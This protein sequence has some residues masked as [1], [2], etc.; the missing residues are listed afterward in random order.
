VAAARATGDVVQLQQS[1]YD[2]GAQ[3][4]DVRARIAVLT[5]SLKRLEGLLDE[6]NSVSDVI[7]LEDAI[8]QRQAELDS[9][10]AQ[11]RELADQTQMAQ[12]SLTLMSPDDAEQLVDPEPQ[13]TWWESFVR[14]L[15]QFWSWLGQALLVLSPLLIVAAI[16]LWVRRRR[17]RPGRTGT[18]EE[19]VEAP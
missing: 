7:R 16:L 13:L 5:A 1:S 18:V 15:S 14:G 9:L 6:A 19:S 11:Q 4:T 3:V 17:G 8:A 2:V 12:V 10:L